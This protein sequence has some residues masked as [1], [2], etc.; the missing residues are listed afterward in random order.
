M[1]YSEHRD[2]RD[3]RLRHLNVASLVRIIAA[4]AIVMAAVAG[5]GSVAVAAPVGSITGYVYQDY[6]AT[7]ING[8]HVIQ[9]NADLGLGNHWSCGSRCCSL[10]CLQEAGGTAARPESIVGL[11]AGRAAMST[12]SIFSLHR[13]APLPPHPQMVRAAPNHQDV[14]QGN[15]HGAHD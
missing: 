9:R 12:H 8:A 11:L 5:I 1:W 14:W 3:S 6:N 13:F 15:R 10:P 4:V 2:L 7:P